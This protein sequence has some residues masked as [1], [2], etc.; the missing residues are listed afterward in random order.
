MVDGHIPLRGADGDWFNDG[1]MCSCWQLSKFNS[2]M[3]GRYV[4]LASSSVWVKLDRIDSRSISDLL[5]ATELAGGGRR[6]I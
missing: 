5:V 1:L 3:G 4:T 2:R 6:R